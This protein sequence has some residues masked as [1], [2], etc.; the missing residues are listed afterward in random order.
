MPILNGKEFVELLQKIN[1]KLPPIFGYTGETHPEK[2]FGRD[3]IITKIFKKEE[4]LECLNVIQKL[5]FI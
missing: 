2:A 4:L 5:N 1:K 3:T